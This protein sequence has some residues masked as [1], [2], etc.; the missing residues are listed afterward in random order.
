MGLLP[1]RGQRF[2]VNTADDDHRRADEGY[3]GSCGGAHG[4]PLVHWKS[5]EYNR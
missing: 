4:L 5:L 1:P 3:E 2:R